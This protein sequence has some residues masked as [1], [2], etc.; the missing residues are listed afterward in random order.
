MAIALAN[1]SFAQKSGVAFQPKG[2]PVYTGFNQIQIVIETSS[3]VDSV[4]FQVGDSSYTIGKLYRQRNFNI[5][6][7]VVPVKDAGETTVVMPGSLGY[8]CILMCY[9][10]R[11]TRYDWHHHMRK[12]EKITISIIGKKLL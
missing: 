7:I 5:F 3:K 9:N 2:F 11:L 4:S 6:V 8:R 1:I 10:E 12:H